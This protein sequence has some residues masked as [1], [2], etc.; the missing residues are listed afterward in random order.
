MKHRPVPST[1]RFNKLDQFKGFVDQATQVVGVASS[2]YS[3]GKSVAP[4]VRPMIL[5][6]AAAL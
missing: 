2:I 1:H 4:Y 6:A 3:L 5:G